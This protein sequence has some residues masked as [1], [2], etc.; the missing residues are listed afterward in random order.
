MRGCPTPSCPASQWSD[1]VIVIVL[2]NGMVIIVLSDNWAVGQVR[3]WISDP[4]TFK[5]RVFLFSKSFPPFEVNAHV[6][7]F[8]PFIFRTPKIQTF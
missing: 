5:K 7:N 3:C 2:V 8:G 4:Q 1:K 6:L